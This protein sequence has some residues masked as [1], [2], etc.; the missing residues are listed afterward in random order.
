MQYRD[1][2]IN[3][4]SLIRYSQLVKRQSNS[5]IDELRFKI[6]EIE[7]L[8]NSTYF[9]NLLTDYFTHLLN[10]F[11]INSRT[12][13]P[14]FYK[15]KNFSR[16][17]F[18]PFSAKYF[19]LNIR[20]GLYFIQYTSTCRNVYLAI[21]IGNRLFNLSKT[22]LLYLRPGARIIIANLDLSKCAVKLLVKKF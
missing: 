5:D 4:D 21:Q 13:K 15:L 22:S 10:G 11:S 20:E 1:R 12:Y 9:R 19:V 3:L 17:V 14:M 6:F 2:I 16:Y 18:E 7:N 8:Y